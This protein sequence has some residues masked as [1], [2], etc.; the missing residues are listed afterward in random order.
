[1]ERFEKELPTKKPLT[2]DEIA[3]I[4]A[5]FSLPTFEHVRGQPDDEVQPCR[6]D[7]PLQVDHQAAFCLMVLPPGKPDGST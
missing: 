3:A 7:Q 6:L 5:G 1:M 4:R 2:E